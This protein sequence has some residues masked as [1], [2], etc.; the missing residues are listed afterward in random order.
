MADEDCR[1]V[2]AEAEAL[3]REIAVLRG[4]VSVLR[5]DPAPQGHV[6]R[7]GVGWAWLRLALAFLAG[8]GAA[9]LALSI[10]R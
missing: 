10:L 9:W 1:A 6:T 7:H 3:R 2:R 4:V 5:R 8:A